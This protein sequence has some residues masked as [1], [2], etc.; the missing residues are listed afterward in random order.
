MAEELNRD[1]TIDTYQVYNTMAKQAGNIKLGSGETKALQDIIVRYAKALEFS[2]LNV[3]DH[4][5][6]NAFHFN[7]SGRNFSDPP[8]V[9][10]SIVFI[11]RPDLNWSRAN[12]RS[13]PYFDYM[14]ETY[15]G[16]QILAQLTHPHRSINH[17][18]HTDD[19]PKQMGLIEKFW[20]LAKAAQDA[21][22]GSNSDVENES[23]DLNSYPSDYS[24]Y[25]DEIKNVMEEYSKNS[26]WDQQFRDDNG[27]NKT[28]KL[29][30]DW[31]NDEYFDFRMNKE[32]VEIASNGSWS[33]KANRVPIR[34]TKEKNMSTNQTDFINYSS[35]FIPLLTNSILEVPGARDF[36]LGS[37]ET[38][39]DY[40]GGKLNYPT[41]GGDINASGE[42]SLTFRDNIW[43]HVFHLFY[44]WVLYIDLVS[45]GEILPRI[46]NIWEKILD[47]TC[48]IYV[49][50]LDKDQTTIRGWAKYTGC[51]PR[52]VP[53][54]QIKHTVQGDGADWRE[55]SIP[56][57]YN[58]VEYMTPEIFTD[59]NYVA[60]IEYDRIIKKDFKGFSLHNSK[61]SNYTSQDI[62]TN[63]DGVKIKFG[64]SGQNPE[65][66]LRITPRSGAKTQEELFTK[67]N[68]D[69]NMSLPGKI[70][71][72]ITYNNHWGGYPYVNSGR[73]IWRHIGESMHPYPTDS[74]KKSSET[75]DLLEDEANAN[76]SELAGS[77]DAEA[78][79]V[80]TTTTNTTEGTEN[81]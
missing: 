45:R 18:Y 75:R 49:F 55:I 42:F 7:K 27:P 64:S 39:G 24:L 23:Q 66:L 81:E 53:M 35:A 14:S 56:F 50:V 30:N 33:W 2:G 77:G 31:G 76:L 48:S 25:N 4:N 16:K 65:R 71:N 62:F 37:K 13:V 70:G 52:S 74:T 51:S 8:Q 36:V 17:E 32:P 73:L 79:E 1:T 3:A 43:S 80:K 22:T 46:S 41:G 69:L 44:H 38:E 9:G 61:N 59:F 26:K 40:Y 5:F 11:T 10:R 28:Q 60:G 20:N 54:G 78:A 34:Y 6:A 21:A 68:T 57:V 58:H 15:L 72:R 67:E 12:I 19:M 47:Y 63:I 29:A